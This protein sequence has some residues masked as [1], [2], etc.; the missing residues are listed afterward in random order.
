MDASRVRK[1]RTGKWSDPS[2]LQQMLHMLNGGER[3]RRIRIGRIALTGEKMEGVSRG[4]SQ[5]GKERVINERVE[6]RK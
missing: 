3:G 5:D 6:K 2:S 4:R 1:T